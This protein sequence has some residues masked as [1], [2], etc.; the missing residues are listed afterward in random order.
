MMMMII[1]NALTKLLNTVNYK[2]LYS[3]LNGQEIVELE[4]EEQ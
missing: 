3:K 1:R 4:C 2:L